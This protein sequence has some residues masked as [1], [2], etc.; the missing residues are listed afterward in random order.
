MNISHPSMES[1]QKKVPEYDSPVNVP[2]FEMTM[3]LAYCDENEVAQIIKA[4]KNKKVL[5]MTD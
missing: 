4:L 5:V 3:V 1:Y 2:N